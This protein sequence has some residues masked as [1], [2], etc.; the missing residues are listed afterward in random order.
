M[1][2]LQG[3]SFLQSKHNTCKQRAGTVY[4]EIILCK[5][6]VTKIPVRVLEV[7]ESVL[8]DAWQKS[9]GAVA[10]REPVIGAI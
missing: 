6:L 10:Q 5:E 9:K 1:S 2:R 3:P 7:K 4:A 8:K